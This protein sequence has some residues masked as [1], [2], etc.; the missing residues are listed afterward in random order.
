MEY[1]PGDG[2]DGE[3]TSSISN[4]SYSKRVVFSDLCAL[5]VKQ[6]VLRYATASQLLGLSKGLDKIIRSKYASRNGLRGRTEATL[7]S[8]LTLTAAIISIISATP[9]YAQGSQKERLVIFLGYTDKEV[10]KWRALYDRTFT[11]LPSAYAPMLKGT[12]VQFIS[13]PQMKDLLMVYQ[14]TLP[15]LRASHPNAL[16]VFVVKPEMKR[17]FQLVG[18][19]AFGGTPYMSMAEGATFVNRGFAIVLQD[20]ATISTIQHELMHLIDCGTWHDSNGRTLANGKIIKYTG[21]N[22]LPWCMN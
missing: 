14:R 22:S 20:Q 10:T 3:Q 17:D 21:A 9:A 8:I 4:E 2:I 12:K 1:P 19:M 7:V 5:G 11:D 16:F 6:E 15:Q 18:S 13:A